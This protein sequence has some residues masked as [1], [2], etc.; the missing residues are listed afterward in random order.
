MKKGI[1]ITSSGSDKN[2]GRFLFMILLFILSINLSGQKIQTLLIE[3]LYKR[4]LCEFNPDNQ[5]L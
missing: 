3:T 1:Q 5:Y 2:I 4:E